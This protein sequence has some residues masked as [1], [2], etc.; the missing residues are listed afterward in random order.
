[1]SWRLVFRVFLVF[2]FFGSAYFLVSAL[3]KYGEAVTPGPVKA[4]KSLDIGIPQGST[5]LDVA[6]LLRE[7]GVLRDGHIFLEILKHWSRTKALKAGF[8]RFES[9]VSPLEVAAKLVLGE[10]SP[11]MVTIPEGLVLGEI[12]QRLANTGFFSYEKLLAAARQT[13]LISDLDPKADDL[14]GYLFPDTYSLSPTMKESDAIRMLVNRF[15]IVFQ[16]SCLDRCRELGM[17]V[18]EIVTLASIIEKETGDKEECALV[19]SV[20]Y[21]RLK[22]KIPLATDPTIIY[23]LKKKGTFDGNLRKND[24]KLDSSYN[25]Y[26]RQGLPPGPISNPGL[27]AIQA[28]LYPDKTDYLYFVSMNNGRHHFS[29][30]SEEHNRAVRLYQKEYWIRLKFPLL[31]RTLTP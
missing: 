19:S 29:K 28:A 9:P 12:C 17:S 2:L 5:A 10:V 30:T 18:R 24:M 7:K 15:K 22:K 8:Y 16:P 6:R 1:M 13:W 11:P 20:F 31:R 3:R 25:T 21:N 14:E 23:A 4:E 26:L 27:A